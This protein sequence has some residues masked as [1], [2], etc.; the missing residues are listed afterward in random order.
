VQAAADAVTDGLRAT[1]P[2]VVVHR[3]PIG[4]AGRR[5]EA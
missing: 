5:M 3:R 1:S 2:D 4:A